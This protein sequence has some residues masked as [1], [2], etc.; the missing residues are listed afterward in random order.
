MNHVHK[1]E[2]SRYD[3]ELLM[4]TLVEDMNMS[5]SPDEV[6]LIGS[7]FSST[8]NVTGNASAFQHF[9]HPFLPVV[10]GTYNQLRQFAILKQA[11]TFCYGLLNRVNV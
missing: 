9:Y 8:V 5:I 10:D 11:R 2:R 3:C 4:N 7:N 1:I 6:R